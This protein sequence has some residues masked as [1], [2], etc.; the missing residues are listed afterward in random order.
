MPYKPLWA[1]L[2]LVVVLLAAAP[3]SL[4]A[5]STADALDVA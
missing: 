3:G 5:Q 2:V 4:S 1:G